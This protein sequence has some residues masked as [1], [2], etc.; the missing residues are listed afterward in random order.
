MQILK[1][2]PWNDFNVEL[3]CIEPSMGRDVLNTFMESKGY[4]NNM[5]TGGNMFFIRR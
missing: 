2:W 5:S 3:F 4:M 1:S